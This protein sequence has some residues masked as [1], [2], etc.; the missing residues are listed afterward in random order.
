[1]FFLETYK[2]SP[3]DGDQLFGFPSLR[4]MRALIGAVTYM[5]TPEQLSM[6][7]LLVSLWDMA[8]TRNW[9]PV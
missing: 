1:M 3:D 7:S 5:D 8:I 2:R 4:Q 6:Q 9:G